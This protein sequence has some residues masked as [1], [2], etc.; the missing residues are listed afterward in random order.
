MRSDDLLARFG[1]D[2]G[3][4][5]SFSGHNSYWWWG[6]PSGDGS[7]VIVVGYQQAS[8]LLAQRFRSV[9]L[10]RRLDNGHGVD[11]EEQG[12]PVWV[13]RGLRGSWPNTW[14]AWRH[15]DG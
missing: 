14:I 13:C 8:D 2:W 4:R 15:Y 10:A 5:A 11:N 7:V 12:Q 3:R 9:T 6:A 1:G